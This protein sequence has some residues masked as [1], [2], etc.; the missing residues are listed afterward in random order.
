MKMC[1]YFVYI[2]ICIIVCMYLKNFL[3]K[4]ILRI[5]NVLHIK[6]S[7][8]NTNEAAHNDGRKFEKK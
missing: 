2:I 3:L 6:I 7:C 5:F 8:R 1:T 4:K